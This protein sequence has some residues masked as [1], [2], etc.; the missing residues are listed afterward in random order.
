MF[1]F[2]K[3][4]AIIKKRIAKAPHNRVQIKHKPIIKNAI[5]PPESKT[6]LNHI[7]TNNKVN[8]RQVNRTADKETS[9]N[10]S[11]CTDKTFITHERSTVTI[12][13]LWVYGRRHLQGGGENILGDAGKSIKGAEEEQGTDWD[14]YY[15]K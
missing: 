5:E 9:R 3:S 6:Q 8:G 12:T 10:L 14:Q 11:N 15:E 7:Q 4:Q 2:T 13:R 1:H